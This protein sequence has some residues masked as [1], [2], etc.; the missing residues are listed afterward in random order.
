VKQTV[1]VPAQKSIEVNVN[2]V[3]K[4]AL[5]ATTI[6]AS[7]PIVAERQDF[8]NTSLIGHIAGSTTTIGSDSL[9]TSWYLPNGDTSKG[10]DQSL[11]LTNPGAIP[12][13]V[14][15]VYYPA[16]GS[17][18]VKTYTV[19][20]S[21]RLTISLANDVGQNQSVGIA[22]Y[23]SLPIVVEQTMFFNVSGSSGGYAAIAYGA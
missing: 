1:T 2:A 12:A 6:V 16:T 21:S 5:H 7:S 20:A 4:Q 19:A 15:I 14:Q 3:V 17:P 13:Q 23:A 11:A 9:H 10:H 8:F 22:L 18:L